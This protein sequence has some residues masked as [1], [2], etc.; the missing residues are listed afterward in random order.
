MAVRQVASLLPWSWCM[1]SGICG[2]DLGQRVDHLGQHDVVGV[3]AGAARAWMITGASQAL[4]ASMMARPCHVVDV[5]GRHAVAVLGG[6][7][8]QLAK[9]DA[10]HGSVLLVR[11]MSELERRRAGDRFGGDAEMRG[12]DRGGRARWRRSRSC[13][14]RR[15]RSPIQRS[16]PRR[17]AASTATRG[18]EPRTACGSRRPAPRTAPSRASRRPRRRCRARPRSLSAA[19]TAISTSEPVAISVTSRCAGRLAQHIGAA[20]RAVLVGVCR[21]AA[22]AGSAATAP[23]R[24]AGPRSSAPAPSIPPSR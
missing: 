15:R 5:E 19:A 18:A 24:S 14:R 9:G 8:E 17:A 11:L 10:G 21:A 1:Q 13:R 4:A 22:S 12:R 2:I 6:V 3:G 16:Q 7:V 23:A 20:R